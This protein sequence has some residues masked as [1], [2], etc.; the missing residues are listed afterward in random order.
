MTKQAEPK[1]A[2]PAAPK[3]KE[4]AA[5]RLV[6]VRK[7][8]YH[9]KLAPGGRVFAPDEAHP[10]DKWSDEPVAAAEVAQSEAPSTGGN[11]EVIAEAATKL[12]AAQVRIDELEA[13]LEEMNA[14]GQAVF[15]E[16][17]TLK[18]VVDSL[19]AELAAAK[20]AG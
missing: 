11:K 9:P 14:R 18:A 3:A 1:P 10:G 2:P 17:E 19:R 20:P 5:P 16:N 15:D 13:K 4:P 6:G 12:A 8:L 7:F